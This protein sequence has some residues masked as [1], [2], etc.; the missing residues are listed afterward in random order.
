M[1]MLYNII[2]VVKIENKNNLI[3][4]KN[5]FFSIEFI[6]KLLDKK[7]ITKSY[8]YF[9]FYALFEEIIEG[10]TTIKFRTL[11]IRMIANA[12]LIF[13]TILVKEKNRDLFNEIVGYLDNNYN[14]PTKISKNELI[15]KLDEIYYQDNTLKNLSERLLLYVPYRFLSPFF[16]ETRGINDTLKNEEIEKLSKKSLNVLYKIDSKYEVIYIN[17]AWFEFINK[18][19][20]FISKLIYQKLSEYYNFNYSMLTTE[21]FEKILNEQLF[22][23]SKNSLENNYY[24]LTI[25]PKNLR[26]FMKEF[27]DFYSKFKSRVEKSKY[28]KL[29]EMFLKDSIDTLIEKIPKNYYKTI[30][31]LYKNEN[32]LRTKILEFI[33][34]QKFE[35]KEIIEDE[36]QN[37]FFTD[38]DFKNLLISLYDDLKQMYE[39]DPIKKLIYYIKN[40]NDSNDISK[41]MMIK[42]KK[43]KNFVEKTFKAYKYPSNSELIKSYVKF[44]EDFN[45]YKYYKKLILEIFERHVLE[46][47]DFNLR[48]L[49]LIFKLNGWETYNFSDTEYVSSLLTKLGLPLHVINKIKKYIL[50]EH[51]EDFFK[52]DNERLEF[53]RNYTNK[54]INVKMKNYNNTKAIIM[55]FYKYDIVEFE[56]V[57]NALYIYKKGI[58]DGLYDLKNRNKCYERLP[59]SGKI[60]KTKFYHRLKELGI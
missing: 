56:D 49:E 21:D 55:Y 8:K 41:Y 17:K 11:S 48:F 50:K 37:S 40:A 19:K 34:N 6:N 42:N 16:S 10:N 14:I 58:V 23:N 25:E 54:M 39:N 29:K 31:K 44:L 4:N 12:W 13:K 15:K 36:F 57:G 22:Q 59:H 30:L 2:E 9:W 32:D 27:N 24:D 52:K 26:N 46:V 45:Y 38:N 5:D 47:D 18:N 7:F 33:S 20:N 35:F 3:S 43:L 60:W 53:W 1:Q 28:D 51:I